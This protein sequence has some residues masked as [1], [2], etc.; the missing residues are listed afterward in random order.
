MGVDAEK[1]VVPKRLVKQLQEQ[2]RGAFAFGSVRVGEDEV[3]GL[4]LRAPE[5]TPPIAFE[6]HARFASQLMDAQTCQVL[7]VALVCSDVL[8]LNILVDP[9]SP[10]VRAAAELISVCDDCCLIVVPSSG[11]PQ[12][13]PISSL[14]PGVQEGAMVLARNIL[15]S[16]TRSAGFADWATAI[17]K[18]AAPAG[19]NLLWHKVPQEVAAVGDGGMLAELVD[20]EPT[21]PSWLPIDRLPMLA[22][23][24]R[25]QLANDR[26]LLGT[27]ARG[28]EEQ[29]GV[30]SGEDLIR[31]HHYWAEQLEFNELH[32]DQIAHWRLG[33]LSPSDGRTLDRLAADLGQL[34]GVVAKAR[35]L[36]GLN[37]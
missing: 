33:P 8:P 2:R 25:S 3:A 9:A 6:G 23:L 36:L 24:V 37:I 21:A 7:Y 17:M 22:D 32:R 16:R 14:P 28:L 19:V 31:L 18:R 1:V 35:E 4:F 11:S 10:E 34:E 12:A 20:V 30:V 5:G 29:R 27:L 15:G 26:E 13:M